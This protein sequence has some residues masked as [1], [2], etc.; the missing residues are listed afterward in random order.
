MSTSATD[1]EQTVIGFLT[2]IEKLPEAFGPSTSL[3]AGGAGLDSLE[4]AELSA[5][6]EDTHGADPYS[7]GEMPQTLAE[8]QAYYAANSA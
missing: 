5:I 3:Y 4:T 7:A 6:L 2:T 1:V 8:I